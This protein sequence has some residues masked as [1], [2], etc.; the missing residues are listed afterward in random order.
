M[1]LPL[2]TMCHPATP[3]PSW[4]LVRNKNF[5]IYSEAGEAA[6]RS[7]LSWFEQLRAFFQR[8]MKV[9]LDGRPPLRVIGFRS[10]EQYRTYSSRPTADAYYLGSDTRDYIVMPSIEA[11]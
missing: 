11:R 6:A 5:A 9:D 1:F 7:A 8:Q 4:T 10:V 3:E 2:G